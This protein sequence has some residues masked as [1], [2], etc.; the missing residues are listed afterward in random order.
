MNFVQRCEGG[1]ERESLCVMKSVRKTGEFCFYMHL[2]SYTH[3]QH[4]T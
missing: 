1:R 2:D 3:V 4:C